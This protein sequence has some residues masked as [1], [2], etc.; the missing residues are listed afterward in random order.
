MEKIKQR[1]E[2]EKQSLIKGDDKFKQLEERL[3]DIDS[4]ELIEDPVIYAIRTIQDT[5]EAK[6]FIKGYIMNIKENIQDYPKKARQDPSMYAKHDIY[7]ALNLHFYSEDT[8]R[9]WND[10]LRD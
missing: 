8:H 7:L 6:D 10:A 3:R 4:G 2:R 9:L 5:S 1:I